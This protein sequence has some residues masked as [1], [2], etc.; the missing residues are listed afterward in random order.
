MINQQTIEKIKHHTDI[1]AVISQFVKL[2]KKGT[3]HTGLCPFHGDKHPSFSVSPSKGVYKCFSCGEAGDTIAF[4]MRHEGMSFEEAGR[5]LAKK[6]GIEIEET[7]DSDQQREKR[8]ERERFF[9]IN[10]KANAHFIL[11][12]TECSAYLTE[13]GISSAMAERFGLGFALDSS[14]YLIE[15]LKQ[16]GFTEEELIKAQIVVQ[17]EGSIQCSDRFRNRL[18]FP[19]RTLSGQIVA[20][21]GRL[22]EHHPDRPKYL[23]SPE[24]EFYHKRQELFGLFEAKRAISAGGNCYLTEG[25]TDVI[26]LHE[27]GI[28]QV[29]APLGTAFTEEQVRKLRRFTSCVTLLLDGDPAGV[30]AA[31]RMMEL[32]LKKGFD[33]HIV[34]LPED[35]DP[36]SFFREMS[37][38]QTR[39]FL[40]KRRKDAIIHFSDQL[41]QWAG[42]DPMRR[43]KAIEKI[44]SLLGCISAPIKCQMYMQPL[45]NIT[46]LPDVRMLDPKSYKK[47]EKSLLQTVD[48]FV[49]IKLPLHEEIENRL[50]RWALFRGER[51]MH[52]ELGNS[53]TVWSPTIAEFIQAMVNSER[54]K[55]RHPLAKEVIQSERTAESC[56]HYFLHHSNKEIAKLT[57]SLLKPD[58]Y[59]ENKD[60]ETELRKLLVLYKASVLEEKI[61][62][63]RELL[64]TMDDEEQIRKWRMQMMELKQQWYELSAWLD[65]ESQRQ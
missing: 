11:N 58:E 2:T 39:V 29:V 40:K 19:I 21:G 13:R 60:P 14:S 34:P 41:M 15:R 50:L 37:P 23:N 65:G 24:S 53:G 30:K 47:G 27:K 56:E 5:Y 44:V 36:D 20:F 26:R 6:Y 28:E 43:A 32:L 38:E 49:K 17:H 55:L 10:E 64:L 31:Y 1:V 63:H 9:A 3:S 57:L 51:V 33:V 46:G 18:M 52:I 25:Y 48:Q 16:S 22:I 12:R 59:W 54:I 7:F 45:K 61:T 42:K 4:L 62:Q 35:A 8:N